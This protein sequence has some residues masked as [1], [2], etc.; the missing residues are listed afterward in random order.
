MGSLWRLGA[1]I[2]GMALCI[3]SDL[4]S[5]SSFGA[6][7]WAI[8]ASEEPAEQV[9]GEISD[10]EGDD[11]GRVYLLDGLLKHVQVF[12][13]L[14]QHLLTIGREGNGP[15]EFAGAMRATSLADTVL[16]A[17]AGNV[18]LNLIAPG[19]TPR[20]ARAVRAPNVPTGV[21]TLGARIFLWD[22]L[23]TRLIQ[24]VGPDG[25]AVSSFAA[26]EKPSGSLERMLQGHD[27]F[28]NQGS[29]ACDESAGL[30]ILAHS[31]HPAIRAFRADGT[32]AWRLE[33]GDYHQQR[34]EV[35]PGGLCCAYLI[36][37]PASN[38]YHVAVDAVAPGDGFV[39][40]TLRESGPRTR[41][42]EYE[43]RVIALREGR[44]V[45]RFSAPGILSSVRGAR[46]FVIEPYPIPRLHV[47]A[48]GS[49]P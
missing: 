23:G 1:L 27:H 26:R 17:D 29:M 22:N 49:E 47:Y 6:P 15:S 40:V 13:S 14:G 3:A 43:V 12:D 46:A 24:E 33:L 30:V 42:G 4:A 7:L 48:W 39:Y 16:V 37:D 36:P 9:F 18:R 32:E 41:E 5:Q 31:F 44:E 34:F 11:S 25:A 28:L 38:T 19:P 21:C 8:G 35:G 45:D 10:V 2:L 20:V